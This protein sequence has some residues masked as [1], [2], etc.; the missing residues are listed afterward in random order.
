MPS[1]PLRLFRLPRGADHHVARIVHAGVD[2]RIRDPAR[3]QPYRHGQ[4]RQV[5]ADCI[6]ERERRHSVTGWE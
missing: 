5:Q 3:Q 6:C 1:R 2:A 4:L